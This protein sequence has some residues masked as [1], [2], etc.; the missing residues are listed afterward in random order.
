MLIGGII[1]GRT[2][3][4]PEI[5]KI[6]GSFYL[7]ITWGFISRRPYNDRR[8]VVRP[9]AQQVKIDGDELHFL[10]GQLSQV[11]ADAAVVRDCRSLPGSG[12]RYSRR[13]GEQK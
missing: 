13:A 9:V 3:Y 11:M 4:Y 1:V 6:G 8:K 12:C 7:I 2:D 10:T 5:I